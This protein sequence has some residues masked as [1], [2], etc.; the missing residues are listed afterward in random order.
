MTNLTN[1][2]APAILIVPETD[3]IN[4]PLWQRV[5]DLQTRISANKNPVETAQYNAGD[6]N[7]A[8]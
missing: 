6:A 4:W 3:V 5:T 1:G 7:G 2:A 8:Y